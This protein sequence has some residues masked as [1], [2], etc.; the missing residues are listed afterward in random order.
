MLFHNLIDKPK[1]SVGQVVCAQVSRLKS[2]YWTVFLPG[3]ASGRL[4]VTDMNY[5]DLDVKPLDLT[6]TSND[7]ALSSSSSRIFNIH[8]NSNQIKAHY[9]ITCRIVDQCQNVNTNSDDIFDTNDINEV[10]YF[11]SNKVKLL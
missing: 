3:R 10:I 11:V 6:E 8:E 1:V 9:F 2:D 5:S 7:S 4:H